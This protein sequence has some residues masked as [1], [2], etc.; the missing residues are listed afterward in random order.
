M[1][2]I[3]YKYNGNF[4]KI[5]K[6][7]PSTTG[8][9]LTLSGYLKDG[10]SVLNPIIEVTSAST[11]VGYN[12]AYIQAFTRYYFVEIDN[13]NNTLWTLRLKVDVLH[14]Y[15]TAIRTN[16]SMLIDRCKQQNKM[17][18]DDTISF[19]A[20][21]K[22]DITNLSDETQGDMKNFDFDDRTDWEASLNVMINV[23]NNN[24][25]QQF[26]FG[27][28]SH[29]IYETALISNMSDWSIASTG[30]LPYSYKYVASLKD[31]NVIKELYQ[32]N[33]ADFIKSIVVFPFDL[34][35]LQD[36]EHRDILVKLKLG[37]TEYGTAVF[38][39]PHNSNFGY[40]ILLDYTFPTYTDFRDFEPYTEIELFI[41]FLSWKKFNISELSG[42][43]IIVAYQ[44]N[45]EN[46]NAVCYVINVTKN[47]VIMQQTIQIGVKVALSRSNLE[48]LNAQRISANTSMVLGVLSGAITTALSFG[49]PVAIASGVITMGASIAKGV[50]ANIGMFERGSTNIADANDGL[51]SGFKVLMKRVT[52]TSKNTYGIIGYPYKTWNTLDNIPSGYVKISECPLLVLPSYAYKDEADEIISIL[53]DY[54]IN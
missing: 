20:D 19:D 22:V 14:T 38:Q 32:Q 7:L 8:N 12:Y 13:I 15:R 3:L 10:S 24:S 34:D 6:T 21:F 18:P 17:L 42:N 52:K 45:Y 25:Q 47:Y 11:L 51:S 33:E 36:D 26:H 53:K 31:I 46:G 37:S 49:N 1:D 39:L 43:R 4:R 35:V 16:T 44:V 5:A 48:E 27:T 40:K 50:T 23:I 9:I 30:V 29:N 2:I 54:A 28:G 41:P